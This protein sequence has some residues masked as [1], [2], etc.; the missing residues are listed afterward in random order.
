M[1]CFTAREKKEKVPNLYKQV[2]TNPAR[3]TIYKSRDY[4]HVRR[5]IGVFPEQA[6]IW[7]VFNEA[8]AHKVL[9]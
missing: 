1:C 4:I 5:S 6:L 8:V 7:K 9:I 2:L 3:M